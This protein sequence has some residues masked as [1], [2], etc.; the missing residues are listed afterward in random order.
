[1]KFRRL[2]WLVGLVGLCAAVACNSIHPVAD[3]TDVSTVVEGQN[4]FGTDLYINLSKS[5]SGNLFFS[6]YS[7]SSTLAMMHSGARGPTA[8]EM[9]RVLHFNLEPPR[10]NLA[11]ATLSDQLK[12]H[13]VSSQA[14]ELISADAVW[15][16]TDLSLQ[17]DFTR[18]L[19]QDFKAPVQITDFENSSRAVDDI[20][21]WVA[22]KTGGKI[23]NLISP[24]SLKNNPGLMLVN[25]VYFHG[26]WDTAFEASETTEQAFHITSKDAV[27]VPMMRQDERVG[28]LED[29]ELRIVELPYADGNLSTVILLPREIDGLAEME[30]KLTLGKLNLWLAELRREDVAVSLP[31]FRMQSDFELGET[32]GTMG[33][34]LAFSRRAD[35][36][37][38]SSERPLYISRIIH[39]AYL[40][41]SEEGTEAVAV[42]GAMAAKGGMPYWFQ[43]N[44]PFVFLIRDR[45]SGTILFM[46][47]LVS[48]HEN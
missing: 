36:T 22:E 1:V 9:S 6:P 45:K 20:N 47:R 41:V 23:Y 14:F 12:E 33:M 5:H 39:K 27:T 11:I 3:P 48:P 4:A 42:T 29:D 8:A 38:V 26:N 17:R 19:S 18:T 30:A 10:M 16:Q 43:A 13:A 31:R 34:P 28:Y 21:R 7:I 15:S 24:S 35:F 2:P 40:D 46:G 44:H 37:G 32:L 25:A